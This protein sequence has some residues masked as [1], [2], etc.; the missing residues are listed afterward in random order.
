MS[1]LIIDY[2]IC[3]SDEHVYSQFTIFKSIDSYWNPCYKLVEVFSYDH[4]P[5]RKK[6][7]LKTIKKLIINRSK[8][9]FCVGIGIEVYNIYNKDEFFKA[10][11]YYMKEES[12]IVFEDW[13]SKE[14]MN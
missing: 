4:V 5:V 9:S 10:S 3:G 12:L 13:I 14:M 8:R 6:L 11:Y 2:E 1:S 7:S